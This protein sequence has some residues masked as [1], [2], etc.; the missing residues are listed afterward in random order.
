MKQDMSSYNEFGFLLEAKKRGDLNPGARLLELVSCS[1]RTTS[2]AAAVWLRS[3]PQQGARRRMDALKRGI[4]LN[5]RVASFGSFFVS[6]FPAFKTDKKDALTV[7]LKRPA[8]YRHGLGGCRQVTPP[9][10]T[11]GN[12]ICPAGSWSPCEGYVFG[13]GMVLAVLAARDVGLLVWAVVITRVDVWLMLAANPTYRLC[14]LDSIFDHRCR[15]RIVG[16]LRLQRPLSIHR[17]DGHGG[18]NNS[19][20]FDDEVRLLGALFSGRC[21]WFVVPVSLLLGRKEAPPH[22]HSHQAHTHPF[23]PS[24]HGLHAAPPPPRALSTFVCV[25][26]YRSSSLTPHTYPTAVS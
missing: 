4:L 1:W 16:P 7:S 26:Q 11:N 15:G 12:C 3:L 21:F 17:T 20:R 5:L 13:I 2:V 8:L 19:C 9:I 23:A 25:V 14:Y 10:N 24:S 22:T 6:K 18:A